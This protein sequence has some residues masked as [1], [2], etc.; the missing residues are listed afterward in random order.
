MKT[1]VSLKY[2]VH[3]CL[4]KQFLT[5]N[6][7]QAPSNLIF[8]TIFVTM[9]PLTQFQPKIRATK[10]QNSAKFRLTYLFTEVQIRH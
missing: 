4:W 6:L 2:L 9:R 5:S 8:E 10:L 7:L 1:R 3:G